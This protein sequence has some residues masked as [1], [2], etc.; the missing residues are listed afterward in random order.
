MLL[1]L[2]WLSLLNANATAT[3]KWNN[4]MLSMMELGAGLAN[5]GINM[6]AAYICVKGIAYILLS[7]AA[8]LGVDGATTTLK[9]QAS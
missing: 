5:G 1:L 6:D 9:S 8:T 7:V 3:A 2:L 4:V